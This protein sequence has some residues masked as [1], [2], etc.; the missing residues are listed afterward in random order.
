MVSHKRLFEQEILTFQYWRALRSSSLVRKHR[1][2]LRGSGDVTRENTTLMV[3]VVSIFGGSLK[4]V[5]CFVSVTAEASDSPQSQSTTRD[6]VSE[7]SSP[8]EV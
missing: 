3:M 4:P 2:V 7:V 5:S 8:A 1:V 6:H